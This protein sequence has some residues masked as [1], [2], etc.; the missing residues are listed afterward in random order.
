MALVRAPRKPCTVYHFDERIT[1]LIATRT[2]SYGVTTCR[3]TW[4]V[5]A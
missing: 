4:T 2:A 3:R 1:T 5:D